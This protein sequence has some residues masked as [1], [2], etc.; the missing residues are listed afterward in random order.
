MDKPACIEGSCCF[1]F[2]F[3]YELL[4][5]GLFL[6]EF[7]CLEP[8]CKQILVTNKS[9]ALNEF[10]KLRRIVVEVD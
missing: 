6:D 4:L 9:L 3:R 5:F 8:N 1:D 7:V 10:G 2:L